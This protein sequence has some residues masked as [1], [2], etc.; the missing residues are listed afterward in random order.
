MYAE[1]RRVLIAVNKT[2]EG[3]MKSLFE[4]EPLAAWQPLF[5]DGFSRARFTLQHNPCE[6]LIVHEEL[7]ENEASQGLAWLAWQKEYPTL[8][9]GQSPVR[10]Q[11]AYELGVQHCLTYPMALAHPLLLR[12]VLEQLRKSYESSLVLSRTRDQLSHMRRHIDRLVTMIWR[13]APNREDSHWYSEPFMLERLQEELARAERHKVPL[14]LAIGELKDEETPEPILPNWTPD[15]LV[16]TKRRCDVVGQYGP[17]GFL[18]LM[19]QTPKT[20]GVTCCK[21][22][23]SSLEHSAESLPGPRG[24]VRAYFGVATA[25]GDHLS[26]QSLLRSAEQNLDAARRERKVRIVAD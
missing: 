26:P 7:L 23:Q 1:R 3:E 2:H 19:V 10:F 5:A 25:H 24:A 21:R 14:S 6:A 22:I 15:A 16:K 17:S 12:T 20:G 18:M 9:L 11:R 4:R 8:F 13:T